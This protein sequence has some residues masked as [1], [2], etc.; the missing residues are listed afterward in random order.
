[1]YES[2]RAES[3]ETPAELIKDI[4]VAILVTQSGDSGETSAVAGRP[5]QLHGT[6][7]LS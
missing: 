3:L 5:E 2:N 4:R 7:R 6:V 1:M